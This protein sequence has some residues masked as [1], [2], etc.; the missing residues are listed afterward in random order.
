[1]DTLAKSSSP[2]TMTSGDNHA[3]GAKS[4]GFVLYKYSD[5]QSL[6]QLP[7]IFADTKF[8]HAPSLWDQAKRFVAYLY[9]KH[10]R[11]ANHA[12]WCRDPPRLLLG[13][14]RIIL[15]DND[16]WLLTRLPSYTTPQGNLIV[17]A[18]SVAEIYTQW[19]RRD[20]A[21]STYYRGAAA[22]EKSP[23]RRVRLTPGDHLVSIFENKEQDLFVIMEINDD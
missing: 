7:E 23:C 8:E 14:T 19:R 17:A 3:S 6:Y 5:S 15:F 21:L 4:D 22:H 12:A 20:V 10:I 13:A 16:G 9:A 11:A 2:L 18:T 1:M